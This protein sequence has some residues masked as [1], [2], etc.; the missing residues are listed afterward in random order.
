MFNLILSEELKYLQT[1][2]K[3]QMPHFGSFGL[4]INAPNSINASTKSEFLFVLNNFFLFNLISFSKSILVSFLFNNRENIL[5]TFPSNAIVGLL[6]I[7]P[8]NAFA[9]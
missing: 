4:Q 2:F 6:W 1:L 9:V 8:N 5:L 7:R 3:L